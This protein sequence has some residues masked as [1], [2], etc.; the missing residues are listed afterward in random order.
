MLQCNIRI[1][2]RNYTAASVP[3]TGIECL[4]HVPSHARLRHSTMW[5]GVLEFLQFQARY[6]IA[7][8]FIRPVR[9]SQRAIVAVHQRQGKVLADPAARNFRYRRAG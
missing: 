4:P 9:Q 1:V 5:F 7:V 2:K 8:H 3:L 6:L